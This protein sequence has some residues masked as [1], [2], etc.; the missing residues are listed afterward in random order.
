MFE[1]LNLDFKFVLI[2]DSGELLK[3]KQGD[4]IAFG[5]GNE[6]MDYNRKN[7]YKY[8]VMQV[9]PKMK[10]VKSAKKV[11]TKRF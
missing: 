5:D 9:I 1:R 10:F 2:N 6:A 11:S 3:N 4:T 7:E 8:N